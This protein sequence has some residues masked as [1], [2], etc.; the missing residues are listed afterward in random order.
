M[1]ACATASRSG[2]VDSFRLPATPAAAAAA[3]DG[4]LASAPRAELD[5]FNDARRRLD[6]GSYRC[7]THCGLHLL[8]DH[9]YNRKSEESG[10]SL[11]LAKLLGLK[12]F[13]ISELRQ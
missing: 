3:L 5:L 8:A 2:T 7:C 12:F 1:T 6:R 11:Q 13:L 10:F 9:G 4:A